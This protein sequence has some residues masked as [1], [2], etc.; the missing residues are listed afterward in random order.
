MKSTIQTP[1]KLQPS[2]LHSPQIQDY[3]G[4]YKLLTAEERKIQAAKLKID[5]REE[6]ERML[7]KL[8]EDD[9]IS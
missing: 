5:E 4:P 8:Y 2:P 7:K 9:K 1:I 3:K 6:K